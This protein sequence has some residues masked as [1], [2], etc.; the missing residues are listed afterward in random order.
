M[1]TLLGLISKNN[2]KENTVIAFGQG[3]MLSLS[4]PLVISLIFG[5]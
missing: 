3:V 4:V 2:S 1:D 5:K